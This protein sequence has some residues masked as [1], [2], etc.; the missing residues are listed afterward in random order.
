M[1]I[2]IVDDRPV[3]VK[4]LRAVLVAE[5]HAVREAPDGVEALSLLNRER[6]NAIISGIFM[7]KMDGYR[8]CYEVRRSQ[9]L[10][11]IPFI[12]YT[13]TY[14]SPGDEKLCLDLGADKY[15][16]QPA[17]VEVILAALHEVTNGGARRAPS[18]S[19][20]LDET[21]VL[22]EYSERLGSKLA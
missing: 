7:P 17:T 11:E 8:L 21:A 1:N 2:L 16:R 6:V 4:L 20:L 15:V 5:G 13:A 3:N 9:W 14:T 22:K 10:R 19:V 18:P 12:F